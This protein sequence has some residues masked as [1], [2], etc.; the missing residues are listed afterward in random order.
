MF[1]ETGSVLDT[2]TA[3][4]APR[5][6]IAEEQPRTTRLGVSTETVEDETEK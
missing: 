4:P 1:T 2:P 3:A 5:E 6:V